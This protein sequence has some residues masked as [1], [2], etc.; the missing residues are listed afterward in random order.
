[1]AASGA[2]PKPAGQEQSTQAEVAEAMEAMEMEGTVESYRAARATPWG[3][4]LPQSFLR[5]LLHILMKKPVLPYEP[6]ARYCAWHW[7]VFGKYRLRESHVS[8]GDRRWTEWTDDDDGKYEREQGLGWFRLVCSG[9]RAAHDQHC[10]A[11]RIKLWNPIPAA[12][13]LL[14]RV[15]EVDV[16]SASKTVR[17]GVKQGGHQYDEETAVAATLHLHLSKLRALPSLTTLTLDIPV[18]ASG[19]VADALGSLT[20]LRKLSV[21]R[22]LDLDLDTLCGL[23]LCCCAGL[24]GLLQPLSFVIRKIMEQTVQDSTWLASLTSLPQL[25]SLDLSQCHGVTSKSLAALHG[26]TS[27]DTLALTGR[28]CRVTA[29]NEGRILSFYTNCIEHVEYLQP[30]LPSLGLSTLSLHDMFVKDDTL[31]TYALLPGLTA[32]NLFDGYDE[33]T[34]EGMEAAEAAAPHVAIDLI[35]TDYYHH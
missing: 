18:A 23:V 6:D 5:D 27:L 28:C 17:S 29:Q 2:H 21:R 1:V 10:T 32:L 30:M 33:I 9:W 14:E 34:E 3:S 12:L 16:S 25:T 24:L 4:E 11:L 19:A 13:P 15:T 35:Y 20:T 31:K 22:N 8:C 7:H 26:C